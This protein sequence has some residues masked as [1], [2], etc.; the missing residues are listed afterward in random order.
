MQK[1]DYTLIT[2]PARRRIQNKNLPSTFSTRGRF[3]IAV[4]VI[5]T[6]TAVHSAATKTLGPPAF[7]QT[8]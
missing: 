8:P 6:V 5:D 2:S 4:I 1:R 3:P 7:R